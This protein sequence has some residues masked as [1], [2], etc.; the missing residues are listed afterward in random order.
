LLEKTTLIHLFKLHEE[1]GSC[2]TRETTQFFFESVIRGHHSFCG[3]GSVMHFGPTFMEEEA[4]RKALDCLRVI[5]PQEVI[6]AL[7][8][9]GDIGYDQDDAAE[10][11]KRAI[12]EVPSDRWA[13]A[14]NAFQFSHK[15]IQEDMMSA[16]LDNWEW[17]YEWILKS[18]FEAHIVTRNNLQDIGDSSA[19]NK[20]R[21][22]IEW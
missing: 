22:L 17:H 13:L 10:K 3:N 21:W 20:Y 5:V 2:F 12:F 8:E 19:I 18:I 6:E 4:D 16:G 15:T 11:R 1:Q 7:K 9:A 14:F